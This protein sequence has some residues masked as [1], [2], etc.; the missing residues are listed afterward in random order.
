MSYREAGGRRGK[1]VARDDGL[2]KPST[3]R[4]IRQAHDPIGNDEFQEIVE[5][6]KEEMKPLTRKVLV[7][8]G[9]QKRREEAREE[10]DTKLSAQET[11]FTT[12]RLSTNCSILA[13][14]EQLKNEVISSGFLSKKIGRFEAGSPVRN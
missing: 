5:Q 14:F 13:N 9:E 1:P 12:F 4:D 8:I 11:L 3:M 7:D 6:A 10:R 2:I